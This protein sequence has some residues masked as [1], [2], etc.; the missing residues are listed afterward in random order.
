MKVEKRLEQLEE[1]LKI[2]EQWKSHLIVVD[3]G[4]NVED[5]VDKYKKKNDVN[6]DDKFTIFILVDPTDESK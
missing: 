3:L 6:P 2:P 5:A 1:K 4:V